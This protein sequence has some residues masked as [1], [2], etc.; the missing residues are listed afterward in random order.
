MLHLYATA[1]FLF[2][3]PS[4]REGIFDKTFCFRMDITLYNSDVWYFPFRVCVVYLG[5][6]CANISFYWGFSFSLSTFSIKSPF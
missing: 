1:N 5:G 2:S 4:V 3:P 6:S